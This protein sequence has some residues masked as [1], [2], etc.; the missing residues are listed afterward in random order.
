MMTRNGDRAMGR[1]VDAEPQDAS[2]KAEATSRRR[3][4]QSTASNVSFAAA[5]SRGANAG[6]VVD[7]SPKDVLVRQRTRGGSMRRGASRRD[8]EPAATAYDYLDLPKEAF[9]SPPKVNVEAKK[10]TML[11]PRVKGGALMK[12]PTSKRKGAA[13]TRRKKK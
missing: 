9:T 7:I 11:R 1:Y 10:D 3:V 5:A 8:A 13:R 6:I 2:R 12:P 4:Q